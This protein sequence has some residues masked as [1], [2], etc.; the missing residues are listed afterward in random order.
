MKIETL[1]PLN[2]E[3]RDQDLQ[4]SHLF[5]S[6]DPQ[7]PKS[8][9]TIDQAAHHSIRSQSY[10]GL[11]SL[12]ISR[13]LIDNRRLSGATDRAKY[14]RACQAHAVVSL[15][16]LSPVLPVCAVKY[17]G[18]PTGITG[19]CRVLPRTPGHGGPASRLQRIYGLTHFC[20]NL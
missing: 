2:R 5:L 16:P 6:I 18:K 14:N 10:Q 13:L 8:R 20:Q 4:I 12:L 7:Q 15:R 17:R 1:L 19:F 3:S 9:W 11:L